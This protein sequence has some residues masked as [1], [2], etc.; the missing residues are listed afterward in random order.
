MLLRLFPQM[1]NAAN[2]LQAPH[3]TPPPPMLKP[4]C[5]SP[6]HTCARARK[7]PHTS[8][9]HS[10]P[11]QLDILVANA[12]VMGKLERPEDMADANWENVL[13]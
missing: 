3:C 1:L 10:S 11:T 4:A 12:G 9:P 5:K 2:L 7:C 8:I 6:P 13:K